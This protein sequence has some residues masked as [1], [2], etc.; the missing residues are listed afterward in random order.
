MM[1]HNPYDYYIL[2]NDIDF[3]YDTQDEEGIFYNDGKGFTAIE[4]FYG[5]LN[6]NGKTI[7]NMYTTTGFIQ[8]YVYDETML[9]T[10]IGVHD[11]KMKNMRIDVDLSNNKHYFGGIVNNVYVDN[12]SLP[13]F[14]NLQVIDLTTRKRSF[15][16]ITSFWL[17]TSSRLTSAA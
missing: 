8:N 14:N 12:K 6:G 1:R 13:N 4:E 10:N 7:K 5:D 3:E 16:D 2:K 15:L 11:L 9:T 17:I